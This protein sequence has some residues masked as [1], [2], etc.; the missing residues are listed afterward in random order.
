[1]AYNKDQWIESFEGQLSI[2]RPHLVGRALAAV[3]LSA[4]HRRGRKDE[5]PIAAAKAESAAL[6][7]PGAPASATPSSPPRRNR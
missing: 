1:M 3:S 5:E 2:L 7:K 4:W 6:D